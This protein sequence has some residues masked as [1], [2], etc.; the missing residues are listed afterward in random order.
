MRQSEVSGQPEPHYTLSETT[1]QTNVMKLNDTFF[2]VLGGSDWFLLL[3]L[4]FWYNFI[5][6]SPVLHV[7]IYLS[8]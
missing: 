2:P 7:G 6:P 8:T 4:V 3:L 5:V 1:A